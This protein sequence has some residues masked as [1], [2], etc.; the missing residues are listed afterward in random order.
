VGLQGEEVSGSGGSGAFS[1]LCARLLA[2]LDGRTLRGSD[3]NRSPAFGLGAYTL[4]APRCRRRVRGRVGARVFR[5]APRPRGQWFAPFPT[6]HSFPSRV[7]PGCGNENR[8]PAVLPRCSP[9]S[10]GRESEEGRSLNT[11][12]WYSTYT[13]TGYLTLTLTLTLT[14]ALTLTLTR[15]LRPAPGPR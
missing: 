10:R 6:T 2:W 15:A 8:G 11:H 13:P 3:A 4:Q 14:L 9:G 1:F 7:A 12:G 5:Y